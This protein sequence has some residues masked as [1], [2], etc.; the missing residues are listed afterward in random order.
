MRLLDYN[1]FLRSFEIRPNEKMSFFLGSG[2]SVQ[3]G[4]PTGNA[5]VWEFKRKI[6]CATNRISEEKFKDLESERNRQILQSYFS[7]QVGYPALNS[8]QEYSFY[9]EKCYPNSID[10]KFFVQSKVKNIYPSI[11]H[12]CLGTLVE[13]GKINYIWTT[14]FDELIESG[15]KAINSGIGFEVISPDNAHQLDALNGPFAKIIKLHGDYRYDALQNTEPETRQLDLRLRNEL[16]K[17]CSEKGL[18]VI[19]YSGNDESVMTSFFET[20][21]Q[22]RPFP[23]GL[24]WC[25]RKGDKPSEKVRQLVE[26]AYAKNQL[27]GFLEIDGFDEL[28]YDL[29]SICKYKNTEIEGIAE[30]H[31]QKRKPFRAVQAG[32]D[33]E[34]IKLNGLIAKTY[35]Q[36]V[37]VFDSAVQNWKE[38][39]ATIEGYSIIA[40]LYKGKTY[41]FGEIDEINRAFKSKI[42]SEISLIDINQN[43]LYK[44]SV[45]L[46]M[47]Y[48]LIDYSLVHHYGLQ[49][50]DSKHK[51]K[52]YSETQLVINANAPKYYKIFEAFEYQLSFHNNNLYFILL[53]SFELIDT[54]NQTN[55]FE[56]QRTL[57]NLLSNLRN[58]HINTKL[59]QWIKF[60]KKDNGISLGI[61]NFKIQLHPILAYG[62]R[63]TS[64]KTHFFEG[65][66]TNPEPKL[67]FHLS[68]ES[69]Q[70]VHPLKGLKHFGPF[71][72]SFYSQDLSPSVLKVAIVSPESGFQKIVSHLN[73]LSTSISPVSEQS[74][75]IDYPGFSAVYRKYIDI[76]NN[77]RS[78]YCAL[79][80]DEEVTNKTVVEFYDL[81]KKKIDYFDTIRGEFDVLIIYFPQKW[82]RF[83]ELKD[84][85]TYFDL[86]D[87]IKIYCA[88]KNIKVQFIEDKSIN[89]IDQAKVIWWLSLGLYVKAYGI[90]WTIA[91]NNR[92]TAYIG[93]GYAIRKN[94]GQKIVMGCSQI[95]DSSGQGLR[96][97]LQ[98]LENPVFYGKTPF[99]SK[100]DARRL[101]L[102]LKDAYFKMDPNSRL[103]KLVIHKTTHFTKQEMEGIAQALEGIP[104][105][106]LL[107]IQQFNLWRGIRGNISAKIPHHYPILRGTALQLDD[108]SFLLWTH[109]SVMNDEVEGRTRNYYQGGRG[110]PKPLLIR[111]FRG[112]DSIETT[113]SEI[114]SLTK[115]NWNGGQLYKKLPVTIDFSKTLSEMA[116]QSESLLDIPYDFRF[117]M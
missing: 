89:Y 28:L 96:F 85:F 11:G 67:L 14:N 65:L 98:P 66:F 94:S 92:N 31:F 81:L 9:F 111:R 55:K 53:P 4:I 107:Q 32:S 70:S 60:L 71:D 29:Y 61:S 21:K 49:R 54:R 18:I 52:Y 47:L 20:L 16:V 34:P 19:G 26:E 116:K 17:F 7:S 80:N 93:L 10:R 102:K 42:L 27:S 5:L 62:G 15:I 3:A 88:K 115:M 45:Y 77:A 1:D 12:K 33:T 40:G 87:S 13:K 75:L 83:R 97:L 57:N 24:I 58:S 38:L 82:S 39:K 99:M 100:E 112:Q 35:P 25:V 37:Y 101:I 22:E 6:Y 86:H 78:K 73:K 103:E 23:Y 91:S 44:N 30:K 68:D 63:K 51:R 2:A 110:I 104:N 113:V 8:P 48:D 46:G 69:Y 106:E 108:Y 74:Y 56:K 50:S 114:L 79:I 84:E 72:F 41:V 105:V 76:P 43:W 109:G 59:E 95:F 36:T 117:F 90:P 64:D